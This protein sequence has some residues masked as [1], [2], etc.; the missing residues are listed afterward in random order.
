MAVDEMIRQPS[1]KQGN[2]M[3]KSIEIGCGTWVSWDVCRAGAQAMKSKGNSRMKLYGM[4]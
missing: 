1:M 3:T 2:L 4:L